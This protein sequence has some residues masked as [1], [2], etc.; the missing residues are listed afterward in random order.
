MVAGVQGGA[1]V[2]GK[3]VREDAWP[4]E[5]SGAYGEV[6]DRPYSCVICGKKFLENGNMVLHMATH[7][8]VGQ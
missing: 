7:P 8:S 2:G 6:E 5:D 3:R 4:H 1:P